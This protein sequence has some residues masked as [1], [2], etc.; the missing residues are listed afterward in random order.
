MK[1][2][3]SSRFSPATDKSAMR[4]T[5]TSTLRPAVQTQSGSL[6][7]VT[8]T[9]PGAGPRRRTDSRSRLERRKAFQ[10]AALRR[11]LL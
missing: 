5:R 10:V 3:T 7:P 6:V 2:T 4:G 8:E 11:A 9:R 1:V